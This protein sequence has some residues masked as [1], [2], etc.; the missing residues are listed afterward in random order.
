MAAALPWLLLVLALVLLARAWRVL[1]QDA[2]AGYD[3]S[4]GAAGLFS[5]LWLLGSVSGA[6]ALVWLCRLAP[7]WGL[8]IAVA[9]HGASGL[10]YRWIVARHLGREAPP[11]PRPG[12]REFQRRTRGIGRP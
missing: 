2:R 6:V 7:G 9:L 4:M 1:V 11:L 12:F 8:A 3:I 5:G 10:A